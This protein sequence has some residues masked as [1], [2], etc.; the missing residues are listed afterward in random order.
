MG[1]KK[2][3][4]QKKAAGKKTMQRGGVST[5]ERIEIVALTPDNIDQED[6]VCVRGEKNRAGIELKKEWLKQR[7]K[8]G[9]T[10][11]VL[12]AEGRSWGLI[13]CIPAEKAWRLIEAPNY[14]FIHCL[15]IIG[16]YKGK[17][18]GSLLLEDCIKDASGTNGV[19][20]LVS[21][22]PFLPGRK[23]FL[24]H[25]FESVDSAPPFELLALKLSK[26]APTP[27]LQVKPDYCEKPGKNLLACWTA[28]CPY[29][30][31]HTEE[32]KRIA[33]EAGVSLESKRIVSRAELLKHPNPYGTFGLFSDEKLITH[34]LPRENEFRKMIGK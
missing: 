4:V 9:L 13:E 15:W 3:A 6:I 34:Q 21:E 22:R 12:K 31:H 30:A 16:R 33:D 19:A 23:I 20:A 1:V 18:L 24:K 7:F 2:E 25:G 5:N 10:F 27:R 26:D 29:F 17:G 32:L 8:E 11:K 14:I 28:Q